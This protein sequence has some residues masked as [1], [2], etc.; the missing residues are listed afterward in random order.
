MTLTPKPEIT[1]L[2]EACQDW[3]SDL[4][5][6]WVNARIAKKNARREGRED[7]RAMCREVAIP[8]KD[9]RRKLPVDRLLIAMGHRDI[10]GELKE[11]YGIG[12]SRGTVET[13]T[14]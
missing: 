9:P 8:A 11:R 14:D 6:S 10:L 7:I 2:P 5:W 3:A 12:L 13:A 1:R 4:I